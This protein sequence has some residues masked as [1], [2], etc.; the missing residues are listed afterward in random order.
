M[1]T[2]GGSEPKRKKFYTKSEILVNLKDNGDQ[3]KKVVEEICDELSP[4]DISDEETTLVENRI[5]RLQEVSKKLYSKVDKLQKNFKARKFRYKPEV[6]EEKEISSS[7]YSLF[8]SDD[9][10]SLCGSQDK[11]W[12][13]AGDQVTRPNTYVKKPL[14]HQMSQFSR[15]RRVSGK[16][17][18]L[19]FVTSLKSHLRKQYG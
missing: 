12:I 7:Q 2:S 4:F 14:N 17:D 6:L 16:R 13:E 15:R 8:Q 19:R 9:S 1:S 18:T 3:V 5:E 10:E 11:A